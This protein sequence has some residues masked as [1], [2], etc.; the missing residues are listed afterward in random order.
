MNRIQKLQNCA[1]RFIFNERC[2]DHV[3]PFRDAVSLPTKV[4][5]AGSCR[6]E[7]STR[8]LCKVKLNAV[9]TMVTCFTHA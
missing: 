5:Y 7:R 1:V 2:F 3:S 8:C 9:S 6:V 4:L